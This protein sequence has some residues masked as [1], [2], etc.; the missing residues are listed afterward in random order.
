MSLKQDYEKKLESQLD[1]WGAQIDK[2]KA[3]SENVK[4]DARVEYYEK[5]DDLRKMQITANRKL[6]ELARASDGAWDDLKAGVESAWDSLGSA[7]K[8]ATSRFS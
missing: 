6:T 4:A 7:V 5:I 8:S 1:E 3:E 2:I